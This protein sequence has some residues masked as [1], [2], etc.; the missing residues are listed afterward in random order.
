MNV[1]NNFGTWEEAVKWLRSQPDQQDLVIDSYYD[2]PLI[3]AA[4]RYW[5]SDEWR[6]V[7]DYFPVKSDVI[8]LDV[9]AGRGIASYAMAQEGFSVTALEPDP[10]ELVGSEAIRSLAKQ[11]DL[12][13]DVREDFSERLPFDDDS[14]DV[15]FA[16]AVLHHTHELNEACKEFF[17]V[18]KPG[19]RLIAIR[20]HVISRQEDLDKFF[21]IHPL[22]KFYG[23]ENAFLLAQYLDAFK[24][25]GFSI[26]KVINPLD[27][28][29]NLAPYSEQ[30]FKN[31]LASRIGK[32]W[33]GI[34]FILR[35]LF[36]VP[37]VWPCVRI[38]LKRFDH[39]PGR[40]YSFVVEK[41]H[42]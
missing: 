36:S 17:R 4:E 31:E 25:A 26:Y 39:R 8:A 9:G 30:S 33:V 37:G 24:S 21:E 28:S 40:L 13:I 6:A 34:A 1:D 12:A 29:M 38:I 15:I 23:G 22:H 7:R 35:S 42:G 32:R 3:D 5:K 11:A 41:R 2:D 10:S 16:R 18:L 20:E 27:S 19:G 14:F